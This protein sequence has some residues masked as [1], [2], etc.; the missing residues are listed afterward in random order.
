MLSVEV[1]LNSRGSPSDLWLTA[2]RNSSLQFWSGALGM[3][4]LGQNTRI[5][6]S[7][8]A[9]GKPKK[10]R[11]SE[12][13]YYR[14]NN[15]KS[16]PNLSYSNTF[17]PQ[18]YHGCKQTSTA[19]FFF[20]YNQAIMIYILLFIYFT[21]KAANKFTHSFCIPIRHWWMILYS[22]LTLTSDHFSS[23]IKSTLPLINLRRIIRK[24]FF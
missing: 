16:S 13:I 4:W 17:S 12:A 21:W 20:F 8:I 15:Q 18:V 23:I 19:V 11:V 7:V 3:L 9:W 24:W 6:L 10:I 5:L 22:F 1:L 14:K 2:F